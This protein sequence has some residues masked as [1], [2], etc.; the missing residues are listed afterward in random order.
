MHFFVTHLGEQSARPFWQTFFSAEKRHQLTVV[1]Q[2]PTRCHELATTH[3]NVHVL[4]GDITDDA[5]VDEEQLPSADLFV[6]A[7]GNYERNLIQAAYMKTLGVGKCI[8]LMDSSAYSEVARKLGIDVAIPIRR[9]LVDHILS[10]LRGRN[11]TSIHSFSNHKL[12]M[13]EGTISD[14]ATVV[15]KRLMEL[16]SLKISALVLLVSVDGKLE[17]PTAKTLLFAGLKVVVLVPAGDLP[18][19][20][21]FFGKV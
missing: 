8:A 6:A 5:F 14:S 18:L 3:P 20:R 9:T 4:C 2:N 11:V 1:D 21:M 16:P 13:V 7:S 17:V 19:L 15:G 10:K 12:E